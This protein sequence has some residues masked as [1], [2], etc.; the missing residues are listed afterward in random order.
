MLIIKKIFG[1]LIGWLA[2]AVV[3]L[4]GLLKWERGKNK[5]LKNEVANK[6]L[7]IK[8]KDFE[9]TEAKTK[10]KVQNEKIDIKPNSDIEL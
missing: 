2:T 4:F 8:M 6:D 9:A 3:V 10:E 5:E 7:D 1:S